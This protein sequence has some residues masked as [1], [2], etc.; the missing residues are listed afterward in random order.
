VPT[1]EPTP[2]PRDALAIALIVVVGAVLFLP[3]LGREDH[4]GSHEDRHAEIARE[5]SI[6]GD[7]LVPRLNGRIYYDKP[8][9]LHW[10]AAG[11]Y[12]LSG[13]PT[14]A[15]ARLPCALAAIAGLVALYAIGTCLGSRRAALLAGL[16]LAATRVYA[17][18]ARTA[19]P[20]ML[21][22]AFMLG[23]CA[24]AAW[25]LRDGTRPA[26]ARLAALLF[27][28]GVGLATL[29]KGPLGLAFPIVFAALV[30]LERRRSPI[31]DAAAGALAVVGFAAVLLAWVVPVLLHPGGWEYLRRVVLQPDLTTGVEQHA[32]PPYHV[33]GYL[34]AG[35]PPFWLFL[36]LEIADVARRR[37]RPRAGLL[38]ALA[39]LV[40]FAALPGKR[41]HYLLPVYPFVALAAADAVDR[42]LDRGRAW[43]VATAASVAFWVVAL[44][45]WYGALE[46][47]YG[48]INRARLFSL[49]VAEMVPR[50]AP[51]AAIAGIGE[52]IAFVARRHVEP[53][54]AEE[55][56]AWLAGRA[57]GFVAMVLQ[58]RPALERALGRPVRVVYEDLTP[59]RD[60][61]P[62]D[63]E[64]RYALVAN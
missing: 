31:R 20:D 34:A 35:C 1:S 29:A 10:L 47:R 44:P 21:L 60:G 19:R 40:L 41:W 61:R 3:F 28:A 55:A 51:L 64:E 17:V 33:L 12:A 6:S 43:R 5:F 56:A 16:F 22:C 24:A 9:L 63:P 53:V 54:D 13:E 2:A 45:I 11:C 59:E 26:A 49:K 7:W 30:A 27:G 50:E 23:A 18:M 39:G 15:G 46:P 25:A 36:A 57:D 8:P 62:P 58:S 52:G 14:M 37:A 4:W 42:R 48:E 32:R 38:M